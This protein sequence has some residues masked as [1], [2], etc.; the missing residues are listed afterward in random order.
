[1]DIK[2]QGIVLSYEDRKEV[3]RFITIYTR[4][5]GTLR[6]IARG[7]RKI[8][9][10]LAGHLELFNFTELQLVHKKNFL[11]ISAINIDNFQAIKD[12]TKKIAVAFAISELVQ[13]AT[14]EQHKDERVFAL[15]IN[16]FKILARSKKNFSLLY[17]FFAFRFA[18][19]LGYQPELA[20]CIECQKKLAP[21]GFF[22][23]VSQGGILCEECYSALSIKDRAHAFAITSNA[24]KMIRLF[25]EN[26]EMI[27]R[28][29]VDERILEELKI[30]TDRYIRFNL[31]VEVRTKIF[32]FEF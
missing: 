11:V 14:E 10:K 25:F 27:E 18:A 12:D 13:K 17:Y 7:V 28:L 16:T 2:T 20:I 24:L 30:L 4:E 32:N 8:Q 5:L 26:S 31:G 23:S 6:V 1:M 21:R 22:F 19:Y 9:A 3:D 15:L 29:N